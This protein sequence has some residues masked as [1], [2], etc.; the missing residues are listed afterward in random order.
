MQ[1]RQH[2]HNFIAGQWIPMAATD[3]RRGE[4]PAT[5][6]PLYYV[7]NAGSVQVEQAVTAAQTAFATWQDDLMT[8][9]HCLQ[10]LADLL[11]RDS[12]ILAEQESLDTGKPL[13]LARQMDIPRSISNLRFFAATVQQFH[14]AA[15][16]MDNVAL[17]YTLQQ[18]LGTIACI[19]PWNLPL[20]LLTWK[21]APALATGNCVIAKP[22][23]LTALTT[24]H[25]TQLLVEAGFPPGVCNV[26]YGEGSTVGQALC[27]HPHINAISFTGGTHTGA[28]VARTAAAQFKRYSLELGG[29]NPCLV[30]ADCDLT[31][32]VTQIVRSGFTNQGEIC[33]CT[34]RI[35]VEESIYPAFRD[36]L[37]T[38]VR[39]LQ[40]GDPMHA[41]TQIGALISQ[42]HQEKVLQHVT[43]AR[44]QGGD[45]LCGGHA[46]SVPGP[47]A[48]G[49]FVAPTVIAGLS[50]GS[51]VNQTEIFGP[52]ISLLSFRDEAE[53]LAIA[54]GT[55]YGLAASV[56]TRDLARAHRIAAQL[57]HGVVWL[58]CWLVRDLRTPFGGMKDSGVGREGGD[59]ALR[60]F[61]TEKNICLA[62]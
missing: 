24:H 36:A 20:Y 51:A 30:F 55:R 9:V 46:V 15:Y 29:K 57:Q 48:S 53:A 25:F 3:Y 8:R 41:T 27:E 58:N 12:A 52:V 2:I 47:C 40:L 35:L 13:T 56:W 61:T 26:L 37:V 17:N 50:A 5:G 28:I 14:G 31:T 42:A 18:P 33:L 32:A 44:E 11:E 19:V 4:N 7:A 22:S 60:F 6:A 16:R 1:Q 43:L 38:A 34:S 21:L 54:N 62:L 10:R 23:E 39:A 45:V 59:A 49:Y